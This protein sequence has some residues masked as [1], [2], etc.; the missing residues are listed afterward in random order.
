MDDLDDGRGEEEEEEELEG[1]EDKD[2]LVED[3]EEGI[4]NSAGYFSVRFESLYDW[5]WSFEGEDKP[6]ANE[7][8]AQEVLVRT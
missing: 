4:K 8:G 3:D 5:R 6:N 2:W 1:D 7:G